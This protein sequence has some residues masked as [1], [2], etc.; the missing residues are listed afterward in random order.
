MGVCTMPWPMVHFSIA[1]QLW[2][3]S[4]SPEFL[5]GSIAPDAIHMREGTT[6]QDKGHT[7]LCDDDGTMPNLSDF[8]NFYRKHRRSD[9]HSFNQFMLGYVSHIFTDLRW[10]E[11]VWKDYVEKAS[12]EFVE[13]NETLKDRYNIE[14]CQI[15]YHLCKSENWTDRVLTSLLQAKAYS[16]PTLLQENE[17]KQYGEHVVR[18]LR[19]TS[20][21]PHIS[22]CYI[23]DQIVAEFIER[24]VH[25]LRELVRVWER[26]LH[27]DVIK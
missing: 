26:T 12:G 2:N 16:V 7:H 13:Q 24:S 14:V 15:E 19:D 8:D 5:L 22:L 6:R 27:L 23:T 21:E 1:E 25:E 10:T 17:V 20:N 18:N 4:P 9:D 11:T 3:Q